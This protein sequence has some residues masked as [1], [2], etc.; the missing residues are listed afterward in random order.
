MIGI[1]LVQMFVREW[2]AFAVP[3]QTVDQTMNRSYSVTSVQY[4]RG[5]AESKPVC[6]TVR[7]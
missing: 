1:A 5:F 2:R 6:D 4:Q 3:L 7:Q